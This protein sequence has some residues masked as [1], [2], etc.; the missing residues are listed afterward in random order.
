MNKGLFAH[1]AVSGLYI[2]AALF[3]VGGEE[4]TRDYRAGICGLFIIPHF[5]VAAIAD[6]NDWYKQKI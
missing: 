5:L 1:L 2:I 3:V 6:S 4:T